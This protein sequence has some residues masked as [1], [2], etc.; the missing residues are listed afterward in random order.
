MNTTKIA[1]RSGRAALGLICALAFATVAATARASA[2]PVASPAAYALPDAGLG[3]VPLAPAHDMIGDMALA[4]HDPAPKREQY[5]AALNRTP[6]RPMVQTYYAAFMAQWSK[7]D[8]DLPPIA[9]AKAY[10][11]V[12]LA[13]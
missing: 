8:L 3:N 10:L 9:H 11:V 4:M 2:T 1:L 5:L 7:A 13:S 6:G 12:K